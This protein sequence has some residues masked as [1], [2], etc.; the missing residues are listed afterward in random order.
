MHSRTR[1]WILYIALL[2]VVTFLVGFRPIRGIPRQNFTETA[3]QF[4]FDKPLA[5]GKVKLDEKAKEIREA[6]AAV[7]L[8]H[9]GA[10]DVVLDDPA[11]VSIRTYA[12]DAEQLD[13]DE[14]AVLKALQDKFKDFGPRSLG[15]V[16]GDDQQTEQPIAQIGS[17]GIYRPSPNVKLG[18]DLQ[19]GLHV[20]LRCLPYAEMKF[21]TDPTQ[22]RPLW[23]ARDEDEATDE[24]AKSEDPAAKAGE[25]DAEGAKAP[26]A[27]DKGDK[28]AL[29]AKDELEERL[30]RVLMANPDWATRQ[31]V[32][33]GYVKVDAVSPHQIVVK[34]N[35]VDE[36]MAKQQHRALLDELQSIYPGDYGINPHTDEI[37]SVP[38]STDTADKVKNIIDKRLFALGEIREPVIQKQGHDQIIV[39]IPGVKDP[40]RVSSILK[41]TAL[42]EFRLIPKHYENAAPGSDSYDEWRDTRT[43]EVVPWERVL[44]E[45][46]ARYRGS[47]LVPN[48]RVVAGDGPGDWQVTFELKPNMKKSFHTFTSQNV[49]SLMAIVLDGKCQM[50]PEIRGPI[51]GEGVIEGN[52]STQ[53]AGDLRL[54]LNAGALPV[55]LEIAENRTVSATLGQDTITRSVRAAVAALVVVMIYMVL[56]YSFPGLLATIALALYVLIVLAVMAASQGIKGVGGITLTLPGVAGIIISIGMAVDANV[57]IF[58]RLREEL[59]SGKSMRAAA[60]AGFD[61]AWTAIVDSNVTTLITCAVLYFLGT[62][63]IKSFATVLFIGVVCSFFSAVTVTRWLVTMAAESKLGQKTSLFG[64]SE[65]ERR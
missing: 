9:L 20:V 32:A 63:V 19:G 1:L 10:E 45:S 53:E 17:F 44:A 35:A 14:K 28:P 47:D 6:L 65:A 51:P 3:L 56:Y 49:K 50:A 48:S 58:E 38:V 25:T 27:A 43:G 22:D 7:D 13:R 37:E 12:Q 61:R 42:L 31:D 24:A 21:T 18:L 46:E 55:P 2:F 33:N 34:T 30:L 26:E 62:S 16:A 41:S 36:Q 15:A 40:D 23:A 52:F 5:E 59:R 11:R 54:L 60:A 39:E 8:G 57:L 29:P 64:V 4:A